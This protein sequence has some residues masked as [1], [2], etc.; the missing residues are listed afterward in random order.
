MKKYSKGIVYILRNESKLFWGF[1]LHFL[2]A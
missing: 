1:V 2:G